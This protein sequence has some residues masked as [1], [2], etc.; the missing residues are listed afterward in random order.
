MLTTQ[1]LS[2]ASNSP[3]ST[4]LTTQSLNNANNS[5]NTT[6]L[7]TLL[8]DSSINSDLST[9][10]HFSINRS[11]LLG[12]PLLRSRWFVD[13]SSHFDPFG[14]DWPALHARFSLA[15]S[16]DLAPDIGK[17]KRASL[18]LS[19]S[20]VGPSSLDNRSSS[21]FAIFIFL[22]CST[23]SSVKRVVLC[24]VSIPAEPPFVVSLWHCFGEFSYKVTLLACGSGPAQTIFIL[25]TSLL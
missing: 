1:S 9:H 25:V 20:N 23:N 7:T 2:Y 3:N 19:S 21:T 6:T 10:S 11:T 17:F 24:L 14:V 8:F 15:I 18:L 4:T 22:Y 12:Q 13:S 16:T 5:R